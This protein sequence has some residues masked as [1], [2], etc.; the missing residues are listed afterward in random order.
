MQIYDFIS[1]KLKY[2]RKTHHF[3]DI[4]LAITPFIA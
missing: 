2:L 3:N 1:K 4:S